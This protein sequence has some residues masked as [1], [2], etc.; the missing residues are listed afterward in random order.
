[1]LDLMHMVKNTFICVAKTKISNP[2]GKFW[3]LLLGTDR[4]ETAFGI[5]RS[6]VGN[7]ANADV[8]RLGTC[9]SHVVECAN[10]FARYP[11]WDRQP[12]RLRMPPM[13]ADGEIT[14]NADHI[15]PASWTGDVSVRTVVVSTCWQLG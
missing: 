14:R 4:L 13:T 12:R 10:I 9:M 5:L 7:D 8:L 11:H 6:I 3:L 1:F 2:E 15:N